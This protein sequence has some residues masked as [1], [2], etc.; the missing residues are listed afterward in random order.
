MADAETRSGA[1]HATGD[2][3]AWV[4]AL[5][6]PHDPPLAAA[7]ESPDTHGLPAI[8]V[9]PSEGRFMSLLLKLVG[10][11]TVVE[12]GTLAGYSAIHLARALPADGHLWTIERE[13]SHAQVA[14]HNLD[15]AGLART[16][17]V[18][19]GPALDVLPTLER[20]AP[21]DAVFLDADKGN[22]DRYGRWA[23]RT[24]RPG[25]LLLGDNAHFF[26]RLLDE[27]PEAEAMRRWH[28]EARE[29]FDTVCIPTPDGLLLGVKR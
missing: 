23:A 4:N 28:E 18:I 9:G 22:Y 12:I 1:R 20:N 24:L 8:Q 19:V 7:F 16:V 10:A 27:G 21:F 25:G 11:R 5:H 17:T 29:A 14:R 3:L 13:V 26:G 15:M 2:L 6:V